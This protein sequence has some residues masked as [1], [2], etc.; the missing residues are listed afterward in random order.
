MFA[1]SPQLQDSAGDT[2][3]SPKVTDVPPILH[4]RGLSIGDL[5]PAPRDLLGRVRLVSPSPVARER[6]SGAWGGRPC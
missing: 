2:R 1:R 4:L 5:G 6:G 3:R